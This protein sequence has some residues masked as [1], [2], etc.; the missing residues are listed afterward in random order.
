MTIV[1]ALPFLEARAKVLE[2]TRAHRAVPPS[3]TLPLLECSGRILAAPVAAD[4]DYPPLPRSVRD[5]FAVRAEDT[6]GRLPVQAEVRAG[7]RMWQPL[8]RACGGDHDRCAHAGRGG[9]RG[10]GGACGAL[11]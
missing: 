3:E 9:R 11:R 4:R 5:G 7:E 1:P 6:P 8:R 2:V 10:D